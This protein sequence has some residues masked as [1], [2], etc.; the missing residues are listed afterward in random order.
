ML[1][2]ALT[3]LA[4]NPHLASST[5]SSSKLQSECSRRLI[6]TS[7]SSSR[8]ASKAPCLLSAEL[9][10][11]T[12]A[13]SSAVSLPRFVSK[14]NEA[15]RNKGSCDP[16]TPIRGTLCMHAWFFCNLTQGCAHTTSWSSQLPPK[17]LKY[18]EFGPLNVSSHFR[19]QLAR[20]CAQSLSQV[21]LSVTP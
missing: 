12:D 4:L 8:T 6:R 13:T 1:A 15:L 18:R 9:I 21:R 11:K 2:A 14:L 5:P 20:M 10:S 17:P 19:P 3:A 16:I 7:H